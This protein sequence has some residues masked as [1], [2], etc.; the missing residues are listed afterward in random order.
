MKIIEGMKEIKRLEEKVDDLKMKV[1]TYCADMDMEFPVYENQKGQITEWLQ[2]AHDSLKEAE[3]LRLAI[4]KTNLSKSVTIQLGDQKVEKSIAAWIIRRRLYAAKEQ[5]LWASL[6]DKNLKDSN[7][8]G[9]TGEVKEIHVR[10]YYDP[11]IRD[12]KVSEFRD[13]PN[14][15]DRSLEVVN[16][17]TDLD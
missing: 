13:E 2:S 7:W 5:T 9:T 3:R 12:I 17:V 10:R 8:K 11:K 4:Q 6:T 15:I 16:A 1:A 14:L